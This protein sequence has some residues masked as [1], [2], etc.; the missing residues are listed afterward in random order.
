[1]IVQRVALFLLL[2]LSLNFCYAAIAQGEQ[3]KPEVDSFLP[4]LMQSARFMRIQPSQEQEQPVSGQ[5]QSN[6]VQQ[7]FDY[8][9]AARSEDQQ[10]QQQQQRDSSPE[11]SNPE[12][13]PRAMIVRPGSNFYGRII[14]YLPPSYQNGPIQS[15]VFLV[16][17]GVP[18]YED[19]PSQPGQFRTAS[20]D[21]TRE[22]P[23]IVRPAVEPV[24][25]RPTVESPND[26]KD[27]EAKVQDTTPDPSQTEKVEEPSTS[28][29]NDSES[30]SVDQNQSTE[31]PKIDAETEAPKPE[32][33]TDTPK[34]E[35]TNSEATT[36]ESLPSTE[37]ERKAV[38]SETGEKSEEDEKTVTEGTENSEITA[39]DTPKEADK[40][41]TEEVQVATEAHKEAETEDVQTE[42][43]E[44]EGPNPTTSLPEEIADKLLEETTAGVESKQEEKVQ[45]NDP[46]TAAPTLE[47]TTSSELAVTE[48]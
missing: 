18:S 38:D 47:E 19:T 45:Q 26:S 5:E 37:E 2:S 41:E 24:V 25:P 29:P 36:Q 44:T 20:S 3:D 10:A 33:E 14:R 16:N 22:L 13:I 27:V 28:N 6:Q 21:N 15:Q 40:T 31:T 46:S 1:M 11:F 42:N 48:S 35:E 34:S 23:P 39:T 43:K 17:G 8:Y 9:D 32:A 7:P 4:S 30:E 12:F